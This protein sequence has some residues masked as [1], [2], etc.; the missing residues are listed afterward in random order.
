MLVPN[1]VKHRKHQKG[2]GR[3]RTFESRGV[4]IDFGEYGLKVL[5]TTWI[6]SRQIEAARK[7]I[8]RYIRKK[9]KLW[10]R[11]F[12]YKVITQ[13]GQEVPMGGGK[14]APDYYVYVA[15]P[16][17]IIFEIAGIDEDSAKEAFRKA[18]DKFSV[19]TKFVKK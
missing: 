18:G 11:V 5:E 9:G 19:K 15:K 10:I 2:R 12:P 17:K 1:K 4:N 7:V 13:K 8:V 16:G 14:G 3:K 6:T